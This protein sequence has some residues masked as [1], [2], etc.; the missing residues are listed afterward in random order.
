M[1]SYVNN[2]WKTTLDLIKPQ[3]NRQTFDSWLKNTSAVTID[4]NKIIISVQ[5]ETAK[6]QIQNNYYDLI[7]SSLIKVSGQK[8]DCTFIIEGEL[9]SDM[10]SYNKPESTENIFSYSLSNFNPN[11][12]FE[13]FVVGP[14]NELA[15]AAAKSVS[16]EPSNKKFN[17]LFLYGSSGLGKTHLLQAIGNHL[18]ISQPN[19]KVLYIP[20]EQFINEFI[21]GIM[22]KT[23][24]RVMSKYRKVDIL[25][26][27][28]IQFLANKEGTQDEFFHTFNE[29]HLNNKQ[30]VLTSDR[31]PKELS[32][33]T[34]RLRTRFEGGFLADI[35]APNL[36]TREAILRNKARL[37]GIEISDEIINYIAKRIR[38]N[39]R[40]LESAL[41]KIH[42]ISLIQ[43]QTISIDLVKI[44]LRPLFEEQ[45]NKSITIE[46]IIVKVGAK[47]NISPENIIS[48]SRHSSLI[49]P[50]F[51]AM[52]I[53]T[54]LTNNTTNEI[55]K[56]FGNRDHS[57]VINARNCTEELLQSDENYREIIEDIISDLKS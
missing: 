36:E 12:T 29:L 26:I 34:E 50:R 1:N 39:I 20:S 38:S 56:E 9:L 8:F 32:V 30:I 41:N 48:K 10:N 28:D 24:Q 33:L 40:A 3:M 51:I 17:P 13:S 16:I 52:Y 57:T 22:T 43:K 21:Q 6:K 49:K 31:P 44:H 46:D 15:H 25:L 5:D 11:Y 14:N 47:F 27:D 55:G 23:T 35:Q 2:M 4:K 18:K 37:E 54:K 7:I 45:Q 53:A 42:A 19:L